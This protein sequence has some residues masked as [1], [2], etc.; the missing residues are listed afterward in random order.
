M[1]DKVLFLSQGNQVYFG[2]VPGLPAY[3][4]AI[5]HE[6]PK[7]HNPADHVLDLI[8]TDFDSKTVSFVEDLAKRY[9]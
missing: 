4:K 7:D 5:G 1:F 8:N 2:S 6:V 3:L 9:E